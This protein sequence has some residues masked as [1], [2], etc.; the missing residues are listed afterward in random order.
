MKLSEAKA[1][2]KKLSKETKDFCAGVLVALDHVAAQ[3]DPTA[4]RSIVN[5]VGADILVAVA[6]DPNYGSETDRQHLSM[7]GYLQDKN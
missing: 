1:K 6:C 7:Y 2:K 3:D 5:A 4:Y